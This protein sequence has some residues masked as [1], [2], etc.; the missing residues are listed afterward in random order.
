MAI[1]IE[2]VVDEA[3]ARCKSG[4]DDRLSEEEDRFPGSGEAVLW[5]EP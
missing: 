4:E 3:F 2:F 1:D 5:A